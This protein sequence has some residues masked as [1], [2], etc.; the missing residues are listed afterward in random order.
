MDLFDPA[1]MGAHAG[2]RR[3][4]MTESGT[5]T[6]GG[7]AGRYADVNGLNMYYECHGDG[8]PLVLLHGA[9]S[10]IESSFGKLLPSLART[11]RV[12]AVEQQGHGHTADLDRPLSYG[13]M[14][15]DTIALL[16]RL[17]IENA[18]V[19]GFS[20]G[21]GVALEIAIRRPT[22]VRRLILISLAYRADGL[23]PE[24]LAGEKT[25]TPDDLD[26]TPWQAEYARIAPHPEDWPALVEKAVRLDLEFEGWPADAVRSISAP[27]L[28]VVG[29]ADIVRPEHAVEML[30]LLGGGV[31]GDLAVLPRSRLA[32]LPGT[33]H[34]TMMDRAGWLR[35]MIPEFL[36]APDRPRRTAAVPP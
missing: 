7:G 23:Y 4:I 12:V 35:E 19:L 33:T 36:D 22:L 26:G 27:T 6:T 25:I 9:L 16:E 29:D 21:A 15:D 34:V 3:C 30:R 18:D 14:A 1:A 13:Q 20:M 5:H 24:V 8:P 32:V 31:P 17:G 28:I 2:E 10:G 11:R